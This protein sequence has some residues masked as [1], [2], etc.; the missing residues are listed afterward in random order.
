MIARTLIVIAAVVVFSDVTAA[1]TI[2]LLGAGSVSCGTWTQ[3]SRRQSSTYAT[4][5]QWVLGYLT[6]SNA[7][8]L[9][10]DESVA[11]G[12]DNIALLAWIDNFCA[13]N[14]LENI[15]HATEKLLQV[16]MKKNG[17]F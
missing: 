9:T 4:Y 12:M 17:T 6:A 2:M 13:A 5:A 11:K 15:A 3:E 10:H 1:R 7:Y 14:P 8:L 16:A